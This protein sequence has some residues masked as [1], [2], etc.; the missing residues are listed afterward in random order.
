MA[1]VTTSGGLN[2]QYPTDG[3]KNYGATMV[4]TWNAISAHDH[5]GSNKGLQLGTNALQA[6]AVSGAK[7]RLA[8]NEYLRARNAAGSADVNLFKF[9]ASNELQLSR[10]LLVDASPFT[11]LFGTSDGAD[12]ALMQFGGSD[13]TRGAYNIVAGNEHATLAGVNAVVCGNVS[14]AYVELRS[15]GAQD[16]RML[17]NNTERLR[18]HEDGWLFVKNTTAPGSNPTGGGY[19]YVESGALKYRGSGGTVTTLGAA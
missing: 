12:N 13:N 6:N 11:I 2:F 8:N 18:I 5:T 15:Y 7:I 10:S 19:L 14:G 16:I 4:S 1:Y 3:T 17:T 9:N